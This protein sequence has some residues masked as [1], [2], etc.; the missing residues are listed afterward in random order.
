[1]ETPKLILLGWDAASW[2]LLIPW[3]DKGYLP[4]LKALMDQGVYGDLHSTPLPVSPAAWTTIIT[5]KNP[6]KHG[7]YDWFS[8]NE[9]SYEVSYVHTGQIKTGTVWNYLNQAGLSVGVFN[10]P[11]LYPAVPLDGFMLS[12]LAAPGAHSDRFSF[13]AD[14]VREIEAAIGP[15]W[16]TEPEIYQYGQEQSYFENVLGWLEY[17][18]QTID[19]LFTHHPCDVYWLVFMQPDHI[20]HKFWRYMDESYPGYDPDYDSRFRDSILSIYQRLDSM[21]GE[22]RSAFGDDTSYVLVSDHGA[23]AVHGVMYINRWLREMGYLHLKRALPTRIKFWL[24]KTDLIS[25]LYRLVTMVG[26]GKVANLVSKPTRNKVLNSFL[27]LDDID[28]SRTKAYARGAFGQIYVN[29]HGREPQGIVEPGT[30]YEQVVIVLM[31]ELKQLKHPETG[32]SLITDIR[33]RERVYQGPYLDM[34]ADLMFS[35]QNYRYQSSVRMGLENKSIL[36]LSEYGDS[37]SHRPDGIFV[38]SGKNLQSQGLLSPMQAADILPT[39]LALCGAPIPTDLDGCLSVEAVTKEIYES[40]QSSS[41]EDESL[42]EI[43][44]PDLD[45]EEISK[46]ESRLMDLGYLG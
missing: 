29:L 8:R 26:L 43:K 9:N 41:F 40:I 25:K 42:D 10:L 32:E 38:F 11:M 33:R 7:V 39:I 30:E 24:A 20:Q 35:I 31:K 27:S 5:G 21:L 12:G 3:I 14:L 15:Y 22:W 44:S 46:L 23:G 4:H 6:A 18:K 2:D 37:G 16:N 1:M 34:A 45:P 17:Q 36:G 13:P 19:Y 28:W